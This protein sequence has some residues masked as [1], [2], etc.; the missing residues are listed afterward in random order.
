MG[1]RRHAGILPLW[2]QTPYPLSKN[3]LRQRNHG[4]MRAVLRSQLVDRRWLIAENAPLQQQVAAVRRSSTDPRI[5]R[6]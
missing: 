2:L 6:R 5:R 3:D 1:R 4:A